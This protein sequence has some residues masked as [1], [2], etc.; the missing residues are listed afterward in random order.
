M[1]NPTDVSGQPIG[2]IFKGQGPIRPIF[3]LDPWKW[4]LYV[5]PK[6]R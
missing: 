2:P 3:K 6:R 1:V 5:V 4:D